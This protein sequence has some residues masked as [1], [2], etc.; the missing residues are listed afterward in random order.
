MYPYESHRLNYKICDNKCA[1]IILLDGQETTT[2]IEIH[3]NEHDGFFQG[4]GFSIMEEQIFGTENLLNLVDKA[5]IELNQ[6]FSVSKT[7][8]IE[9]IKSISLELLD[10]NNQRLLELLTIFQDTIDRN[11][12]L[13]NF[14][15]I[16]LDSLPYSKKNK[17]LVDHLS[18]LGIH[19]LK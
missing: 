17:P 6:Y 13:E 4:E 8:S 5:L 11:K 9:Q 19:K 12:K 14:C 18:T 16:M 15:H 7:I 2:G 10:G 3:H 1:L